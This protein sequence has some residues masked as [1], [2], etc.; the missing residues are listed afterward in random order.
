MFNRL[1]PRGLLF[2]KEDFIPCQLLNRR[3]LRTT[4]PRLW[5]KGIIW[6]SSSTVGVDVFLVEKKDSTLRRCIDYARLNHITFKNRYLLPLI[7]TTFD[8]LQGDKIITKLDLRNAYYLVGIRGGDEWKTAFDTPLAH[9][10]YLMM[11]FRL[12]NASAVFWAFVNLFWETSWI[13][14]FS[15]T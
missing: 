14:K 4:S 9:Y 6:P 5:K 3:L 10:E 15:F 8:C 7:F 13:I 2:P 11:P 1:T 12:M